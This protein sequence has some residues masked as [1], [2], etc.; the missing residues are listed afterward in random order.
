MEMEHEKIE[1]LSKYQKILK[2]IFIILFTIEIIISWF[3]TFMGLYVFI[4]TSL[5]LFVS[6]ILIIIIQFNVRGQLQHETKLE[7]FFC[8]KCETYAFQPL[9]SPNCLQCNTVMYPVRYCKRCRQSDIVVS[10]TQWTCYRCGGKLKR[11]RSSKA[12]EKLGGPSV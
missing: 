1:R 9:H 7:K 11:I 4:F 3:I 6:M 5:G 10:L 8:P 2:I 12:E